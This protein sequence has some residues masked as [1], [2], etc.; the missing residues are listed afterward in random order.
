M[1]IFENTHF[2]FLGRQHVS[3]II[4]GVLVLIS[5][6]SLIYPGLEA[7]IDFTG[8]T[9]L[10]VRTEAPVA[11][12]EARSALD[13][14]LGAGTETKLFGDDNT[15]LVRTAAGGNP[16]SLQSAVTQTLGASFAGSN[17][18]ILRIDSVGPRVAEDLQERAIL[19][20]LG[21]LF[22]ILLYI[23]VR[24]DWRFAVAAVLTLAHDVLERFAM[25]NAK[26]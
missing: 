13:P 18:E 1:R 11:P 19:L 24:F 4:S 15:L 7:G 20:V 26:T 21:A 25:N 10:V 17:P 3:Y 12:V 14:V 2:D 8:G 6:V 9:E 22:V 23:F 16:D 5:V